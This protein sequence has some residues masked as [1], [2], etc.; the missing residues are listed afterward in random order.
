MGWNDLDFLVQD[1]E[2]P[3][4]DL[5]PNYQKAQHLSL[6]LQHRANNLLNPFILIL[7]PRSDL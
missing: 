5:T 2:R 6:L 3:Y 1:T 7:S 4:T